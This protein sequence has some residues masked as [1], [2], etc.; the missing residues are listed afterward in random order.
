ISSLVAS[1]LDH[2]RRSYLEHSQA[3][4]EEAAKEIVSREQA[5]L[6]ESAEMV[7][8]SLADRVHGVTSD[9]LRKFEE[10][11]RQ[12]L[13]KARSDMEYSREGSLNDFQKTLDE[14]MTQS[15]EHANTFLQSQ[16]GPLIETLQA[17]RDAQQKQW[18]E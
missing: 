12:A 1:E 7:H 5:K 8:A 11:S 15:V 2:Y 17:S 10:A 13:E 16:L 18:M 4:I 14:K 6:G 3:E 9:S